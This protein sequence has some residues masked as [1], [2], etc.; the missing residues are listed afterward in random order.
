MCRSRIGR[1]TCASTFFSTLVLCVWPIA[2]R[3]VGDDVTSAPA[4]AAE[5][6]SVRKEVSASLDEISVRDLNSFHLAFLSRCLLKLK[7]KQPLCL[8]Y[9]GIVMDQGSKTIEGTRELSLR[10]GL[11]GRV[12]GSIGSPLEWTVFDNNR[13]EVVTF[14]VSVRETNDTIAKCTVGGRTMFVNIDSARE[15]SDVLDAKC[16]A[17]GGIS[18]RQF[19]KL[20]EKGES[21]LEKP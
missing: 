6:D 13:D 14:W 5:D 3:S 20:I 1:A 7:A 15:R 17:I 9:Q 19:V 10:I 16:E 18:I 12:H 21:D 2:G 8:V 11:K 4:V